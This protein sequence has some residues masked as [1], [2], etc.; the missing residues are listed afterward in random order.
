MTSRFTDRVVVVTGSASGLGRSTARRMASE[1]ATVA[2]LDVDG[3]GVEAVAKE[4]N[5]ER[6]CARPFRCDVSDPESV[7]ST[8]EA[9]TAELGRLD[10]LCNVAGV[11]LFARTAELRYEEWCRVLGVNLTGPFL[12]CQAAVPHLVRTAGNIVNVAS[13]SAAMGLPFGSAY[14]ASKGGLVMFTKSLAV[15]LMPRGVR[16]NAVSPGGMATE[17]TASWVYPEG[18]SPDPLGR[19]Y[20]PL[21]I[22]EPDDVAAVIAFVASDEARR[23]TGAVVPA[24]GG[25]TA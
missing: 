11:G 5:E 6:D 17:M 19:F 15:E 2:C 16:V 20:T 21:G 1:G 7:R 24:D 18:E 3:A 23:I 22:G 9:L 4:L 10:V 8:F 12:T 13:D 14:S 25:S